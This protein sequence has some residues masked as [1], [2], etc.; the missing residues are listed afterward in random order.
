MAVHNWERRAEAAKMNNVDWR[1][2]RRR[3]AKRKVTNV[4][5]AIEV[6][7]VE[8]MGSDREGRDDDESAS[9]GGLDEDEFAHIPGNSETCADGEGENQP[10]VMVACCD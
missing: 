9:E 5:K 4:V 7:A 8:D 10:A 3:P 2:I 1:A 6:L